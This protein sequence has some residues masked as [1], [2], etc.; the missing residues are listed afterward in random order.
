MYNPECSTYLP[1]FVEPQKGGIYTSQHL[2]HRDEVLLVRGT[3]KH[4][5][6]FKI[7]HF[8][9]HIYSYDSIIVQIRPDY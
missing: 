4:R 5:T 9:S 2:P 1:G 7:V 3:V 8:L 6:N